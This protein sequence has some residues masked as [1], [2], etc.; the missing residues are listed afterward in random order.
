MVK[1]TVQTMVVMISFV[2]VAVF[3]GDV[4]GLCPCCTVKLYMKSLLP[5]KN[6]IRN[7]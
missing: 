2:R 1:F 5:S 7:H 4:H 3:P 6:I